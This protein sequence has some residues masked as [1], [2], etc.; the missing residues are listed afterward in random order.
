VF[1]LF[2]QLLLWIE[3]LSDV[4]VLDV[5]QLGSWKDY[6]L[7]PLFALDLGTLLGE[8]VVQ[9][10]DVATIRQILVLGL[11]S[12]ILH[13]CHLFLGGLAF[14][15]L[16][17]LILHVQLVHHAQQLTRRLSG[18]LH[19]LVVLFSVYLYFFQKLTK[20]RSLVLNCNHFYSDGLLINANEVKYFSKYCILEL[21]N[22]TFLLLPFF[23]Q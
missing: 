8:S 23:L 15:L 19:I 20:N 3:N 18:H 16:W 1:A 13:L 14:V 4:C 22:E 5:A 21:I 12:Q 17:Q 6:V 9:H 2:L 10:I 7:L 11:S